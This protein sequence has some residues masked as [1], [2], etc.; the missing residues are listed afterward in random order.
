VKDYAIQIKQVSKS[1]NGEQVLS[2][3]NLNIEQGEFVG[4]IGP[5]G[6]GKSTLLSILAGI[7]KPDSGE[8]ILNGKMTSILDIGAGFHPD[9]SGRENIYMVASFYGFSKAY[10][11]DKIED[12]IAFSESSAYIDRAVKTYSSGMYLRLAFAIFVHFDFDILLLDEVLG[13]GDFEFQHKAKAVLSQIRNKGKTV[14]L[15]THNLNE[16]AQNC[17]HVIYLDRVVKY[18]GIELNEGINH[19]L[20][21]NPKE[22]KELDDRWT[23]LKFQASNQIKLE[24]HLVRIDQVKFLANN[25]E[26]SIFKYSEQIEIVINYLC[27]TEKNKLAIVIKLYDIFDN[28]VLSDSAC[29]RENYQWITKEKGQHQLKAI[30]PSDFF[31]QGTYYLNIL[32]IDNNIFE[33]SWHGI[34]GFQIELD[35]WMK[36]AVWS[37]IRPFALP[38][39]TWIDNKVI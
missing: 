10:T 18:T 38:E 25:Q 14:I 39:L 9:L 26:K 5:N 12:I 15:V 37:G 16:I 4:I 23:N 8:I 30:L 3:I 1:F 33:D 7:L 34:A 21:D 27:K 28:L 22:R 11:Q 13:V 29:F 20:H 31:G 2:D 17:T 24:N 19:Y 32:I 36:S 6:A 35:N